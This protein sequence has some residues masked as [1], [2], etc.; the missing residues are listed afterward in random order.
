MSDYSVLGVSWAKDLANVRASGLVGMAP[1]N[2]ES[3]AGSPLFI[4]LMYESGEIPAR[5]FSLYLTDYFSN[6]DDSSGSKIILGGYSLESYA[7]NGAKVTWH[8][9][10][11]QYYWSVRLVSVKVKDSAGLNATSDLATR[12]SIAILDSGTS[13]LLMPVED[14]TS[15]LTMLTN[16]FGLEFQKY[17]GSSLYSAPCFYSTYESLP[18]LQ[19]Q[20]DQYIYTMP[21][22]TLFVYESFN[23]YLLAIG[24]DFGVQTS[25]TYEDGEMKQVKSPG[26]WILGNNFLHNYY[27]I[28]DLENS[29]VGLV[30]SNLA[31]RTDVDIG[32]VPWTSR[33]VADA[34]AWFTLVFWS[35]II[36]CV[37][38]VKPCRKRR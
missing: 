7:Q 10:V 16:D 30:P 6:P 1:R 11:N 15:L 13:Y 25:W 22:H 36:F 37:A 14:F 33:D 21:R 32:E 27:S 12:S 4:D 20:I 9:L 24:R 5:E 35:I 31:R 26:I 2:L 29:R 17:G 28:Y 38:V 23:C 19:I 34:L 3:K 18:D 8:S